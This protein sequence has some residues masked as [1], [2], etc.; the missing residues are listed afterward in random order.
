MRIN[1]IP[2]RKDLHDQCTHNEC[3]CE[4]ETKHNTK[5][6]IEFCDIVDSIW[7]GVGYSGKGFSDKE[8]E[9]W[10][11]VSRNTPEPSLEKL[12]TKYYKGM[13]QGIDKI[14]NVAYEVQQKNKF[15]T[16]KQ[17]D[18]ILQYDGK[19]YNF[20]LA[21]STIKE[22]TEKLIPNCNTKDRNEV[23]NKIKA[24]TY[25]D[26]EK[27]DT[28]P[29]L[30]TLSNGILNLDTLEIKNHT[31][32]HLS[33]ILFPVEYNTPEFE[34]NDETIFEDIEKNLKDTLFWKF[35]KNSFTVNG[36][37][38]KDDFETVLEIMASPIIKRQIDEKATIFLGNGENG[39]SVC[40]DYIKSIYGIHNI[41]RVSLQQIEEDKFLVAELSGMV[42]NIFTDLE[43]NELRHASKIKAI[44][45][46]EGISAQKKHQQPFVLYPFCKL[47]F[48][49]NRFPK[50]Y[51]QSHAFF[52]RWII[53]IWERNFENDPERIEYLKEKLDAN[54]E[55]KN[56][57]FSCLVHLAKRLSKNGKYTHNKDAKTIQKL[58]NANADPIED[59]VIN[60]TMYDELNKNKRE[61]HTFY[62]EIQLSKGQTP[63]GIGQFNKI[64]SEYYDEDRT[65][66]ERVWRNIEFKR[67][68]QTNLKD[69]DDKDK[70]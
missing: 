21:E 56:L 5:R 7:P 47:I 11:E 53:V 41:S 22:E 32:K 17:T 63:L 10:D 20:S 25:T 62:K 48:S 67:P 69:Y 43:S 45:T 46:N 4:I 26:I 39:K 55:E 58:W 23:I 12:S 31:H 3:L 1:C 61:T 35:L 42:L 9:E 64:F 57:V 40:M 24:Q 14:D 13:F 70:E 66:R 16:T 2:C 36:K 18:E 6:E 44:I 37:F 33:R 34:I 52:R 59:F 27:F 60:Y 30:I 38:R 28:D 68:I 49:C 29:N 51:D 54:Q 65:N 8:I 15:R 50:V 19:I